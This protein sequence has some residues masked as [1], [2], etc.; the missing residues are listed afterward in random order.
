MNNTNEKTIP[1][2]TPKIERVRHE[3]KR[4]TLTVSRAEN[5]TPA[6][7]RLTF[8]GNDLSD[9]V[10]LAPDDHVK[11]FI[12]AAEGETE[13][14]DY[15]P[16]GYDTQSRQLIID[17]ALHEAGPATRWALDARPGDTLEIGGPRGSAVI[18]DENIKNWLLIGDETAL[19]AIGRRIEEAGSAN[20]ITS[21][22]SIT[23]PEERQLFET[24]ADLTALWTY[25]PLS[26]AADA[27]SLLTVIE[28][29][30][31]QPETFVWVAAEASVTRAIRTYLVEKRG[32][33]LSWT[34]ASGYWVMG[35]ADAHEKFD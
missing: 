9:F 35:K 21:I 10:S 13:R 27:S 31:L 16:R 15:T 23:G 20:R 19:P 26:Q 12:P 3:I 24:Q 34:K 30:D 6:M 29:L 25:R 14:R 28:T 18:S 17:F 7:L 33:S 5:I 22:V 2:S 4:R 8:T 32:H 11:I 1:S